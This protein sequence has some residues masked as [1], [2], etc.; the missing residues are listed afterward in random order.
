[1]RHTRIAIRWLAV[2]TVLLLLYFGVLLVYGTATD[3]RPTGS[4]PLQALQPA[5]TPALEDS[6]LSVVTWNIGYAGLGAESD[7]FYEGGFGLTSGGKTVR[8]ERSLVEKNL[9]GILQLA[10]NT[11]ADFFLF[12]EVDS[13]SKRS[14]FL[15]QTAA[16]GEALPDFGLWYAENYVVRRVP[17]PILE[18]WRPYG[19]TNS[20]LLTASRFQPASVERVQLPGLYPWPNRLFQLDRC[21][22]VARFP[23]KN[24]RELVLVNVH[25]AAH[26]KKG[27]IKAEQMTFLQQWLQEE[28][29][30][31]GNYVL[32]GGDWNQC[33]PFF[34]FDKFMPAGQTQYTGINIDPGLFPE[35]WRWMYDP[36]TPTNRRI[37]TPY[38]KGESFVTTIDYFLISPNLNVRQV[39][40]LNQDF[41]FS[42]HQPVW[43]EVELIEG[44]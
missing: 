18:P 28:Y 34:P 41:Q 37:K 15:D 38:V 17:A 10:Q 40:V 44:D 11:Q 7:F 31:K 30:Q 27:V 1:M 26:D 36:D 24:G 5:S 13:A 32:A 21:A 12:Q 3:Y 43:I 8:T 39:R 33:P 35:D 16:L 4:R 14:Y 6:V 29:E 23:L 25:N 2:F 42:D 22:A 9:D 20:G 19:R